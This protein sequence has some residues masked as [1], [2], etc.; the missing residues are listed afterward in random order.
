MHQ[1]RQSVDTLTRLRPRRHP[2]VTTAVDIACWPPELD[3]RNDKT[4]EP[5]DEKYERPENDDPREQRHLRDE[6]QYDADEDD[7]EAANRHPVRKVP[8]NPELQ[9]LLDRDE[10]RKDPQDGRAGH[11]H[12]QQPEIQLYRRPPVSSRVD[13]HYLGHGA[14]C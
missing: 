13:P 6:I 1:P 3:A 14:L 12:D 8:G 7:A 11:Q 10:V 2:D 5:E 9:L 4:N